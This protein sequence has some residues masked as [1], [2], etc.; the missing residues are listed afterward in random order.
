MYLECLPNINPCWN[1]VFG[2]ISNKFMKASASRDIF[3][4]YAHGGAM[5][6]RL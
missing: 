6:I 5:F 4:H 1:G 2:T 3:L